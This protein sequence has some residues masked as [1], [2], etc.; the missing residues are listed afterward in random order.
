MF[1]PRFTNDPICDYSLPEHEQGVLDAVKA[2]ESRLGRTYPA[3]IGG[4]E[5]HT[6][7]TIASTC[8][9]HPGIEVGRVASCTRAH[10]DEAIAAARAAF[11]T[12]SRR[13]PEERAEV[14][15]RLAELLRRHRFELVALLGYE[16]G[17][18]WYEADAEIA[19]AV[20]FCEYYARLALTHFQYHPLTRLPSEDNC[21][22]YIPLGV[23]AVISP[24]NFPLAILGG[25]TMAAVVSGNT[26]V[27]KPSSDTPVIAWRLF[28]LA[29]EAGLPDGVVNLVPGSGGEIG[30]YLVTHPEVR[31]VAFTGSADIGLRI[32]EL[33]ARPDPRRRWMTRYVSEM[34]GKNAIIVDDSA[35]LDAAS[36]GIVRSAFGF[37]GQKCSACSRLLVDA[38]VKEKLLELVLEK[39]SKLTSG[40]PWSHPCI[41]TGPVANSS[42]YKSIQRAIGT[43]KGEA[44]LLAGGNALDRDGYFIAPTVFDGVQPGSFLEQEEIFGPV[45]GVVPVESFDQALEIANGTR[46][47]LT[48]AVYS[49]RIAH[50]DRARQEFHCGNLYLNRG[51]TGALVGVHPFGGF[52]L[53]GTDSKAGGPDYLLNFTQGKTTSERVAVQRMAG[54]GV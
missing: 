12:W 47:G 52:N 3:I 39:T 44:R 4:R 11:A 29:R 28:E 40:D 42:A 50:L 1:L 38:R 5:V 54:I 19:E 36:S 27:V 41:F 20:D 8:P 10:V 24:W 49:Q 17:K 30:D 25:M 6:E 15:L 9:A 43:G 33:I 23:G 18:D 14:L 46:Y 31:F 45:L 51:S 48:G 16:I 7:K 34:G 22:F 35:D 21:Y 32:N 37:Q 26:V 2:L 13:S 53:S